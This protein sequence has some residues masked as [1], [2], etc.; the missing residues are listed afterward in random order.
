MDAVPQ[1]DQGPS[2]GRHHAPILKCKQQLIFIDSQF[3]H[4]IFIQ[5]CRLKAFS[6]PL[7]QLQVKTC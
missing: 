7:V 1:R 6:A 2:K 5:F 4:K 3:F